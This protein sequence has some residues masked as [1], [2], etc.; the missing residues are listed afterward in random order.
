MI[1]A[2]VNMTVGDYS[3]K[4]DTN[5]VLYRGDR[6]VEIRF[7]IKGNRFTV[8]DSTYAQM[9]IRRPSATSV[10]SDPAP[11]QNDTVVFTISEDMIDELK[12]IG[13]YTFQ[14][15]LYD[16]SMNARATLPPCEGCLIINQ[17]IATEGEAL[18]NA[19]MI[20]DSAVLAAAYSDVPEDEIFD[21]N[22]AYNRTVW[23]DGDIITDV[24]MNKIENAL[25]YI[26]EKGGGG[27]ATAPYI[28]TSLP[29]TVMIGSGEDF[30]LD[31]DF[32]SP[33]LGK[34]T[35]KVFINDVDSMNTK[36]DQGISITTIPGSLFTKGTN[37]VVI[38]VLD[39]VGMMSNSLTFY[40]RYGGTEVSSTFDAYVSYDYGAT[41]RY[42]FT[43]TALDTSLQLTFYMEIDGTTQAGVPCV[44]DVRSYYTFPTNLS[45][46]NHYCRAWVTDG[47]TRSN[48]LAF[49]LIILDATSLVVATDTLNPTVEEGTQLV[50]DYKVYMK[51]NTSF[52]TKTYVDNNLIN[53][54]TCTLE[55]AYYRTT[56]LTAGTHTIKV[57][58]FDVTE[59][60]SDFVTW[61]VTVTESTYTMLE[62]AKAGSIFMAT[63]YNK[64]NVDENR[65]VWIGSS[66]DDDDITANLSNFSFNS[67]NGWIDDALVISGNSWVEIPIQPLANNAQYGFTL[68]IEF[69]TKA[70]GVE[71][72]EVLTLWNE[73]D[74]CG[75]KITTEQLIMRSKS[76]SQCDLYFAEDE[77][78]S[79]IFVIDRDEKTAK[80]YLNGVMCE[81]F[82]LS[83]YEAAGQKYLEDFTVNSNVYLGGY[84]KNGYCAI[85][86]IR[87]YEVAL[88]TNEILNNF[89][90]N[91]KDKAAQR[92]LVEFQKGNTLPT[93]TIYCDFAGLGKDDKKPCNIVYNSPDVNLYGESFTLDGKHSMLQYQGTSSMQYPIKNYRINPRNADGKVKLDPFNN[94]VGESRFTLKADFMSSGHWQNTG[95]AKWVNDKLYNYNVNDES[96]MNAR[97]WYDL[98]NGGSLKG[99]REAINGFPCRLILVNDGETAL[100]EGQ[101]EPTPGNT[102]DMGIFNFNNDKDNVETLGFDTDIFPNCMSFEVTANSDTSAGAFVPYNEERV[103]NGYMDKT[104]LYI[105]YMYQSEWTKLSVNFDGQIHINARIYWYDE[106]N[107][108]PWDLASAGSDGSFDPTYRSNPYFQL[109]F[110]GL[111]QTNDITINDITYKIN[112]VSSRA[113]LYSEVMSTVVDE[114]SELKYLQNSF[115]LRYPDADDVGKDYGY[116]GMPVDTKVVDIIQNSGG[117]YSSSLMETAQ[118]GGE[119]NISNVKGSKYTIYIYF[120]GADGY[121]TILSSWYDWVQTTGATIP[122][123]SEAVYV[124]IQFTDGAD[125]IIV[126]GETYY[127]GNL[128]TGSVIK[129]PYI[130]STISSDYGL[131]RVIDW[132]GNCTDEQFVAEFDQYFHRDYTLRY[133]LLVITLG[134]VDNLGKNM[135][136]DTFD[137]KIWLPRFYDMD[138]ICSYDNSGEIKFDVDI[139]MEQGYWNTSSSRLWTKIRDLMHDEL[140]EKYN[141]MRQ[142][143]M[144][145][146]SFMSYFYDK[147]IA[148]IPQTYYNKDY[149]VKYAPYAD[150]Y[151]GKAHGDGYEHL[152]RWLKRRL[153]FT[154]TLFDY[155]PSYTND[156]LTIRA[157]TLDLM[158]LEIE[159]YTPVYQHVSF[160]NGNMEKIK[161]DGKTSTVFNGTAQTA[162]D[163]EV[164][165]YGGSNIKSIKGIQSMNPD[166]M[167]IGNATRL[168]EL[169]I[170]DCPILT[171]VN[172]NKAN[173]SPHTYLNKLDISNCPQLGGTLN[174]S[175]SPLLQE[176]NALGSVV[177]NVLFSTSV[178]NLET[179]RVPK[180]VTSLALNDAGLL[181]T[182]E[183]EEGNNL[184]SISLTNCNN[185][186][187]TINFDLTQV[188][189]VLLDNSYNGEE[190][191]MSETTNLTLKNMPSL[192]RVIFTP[193]SEYSAFDINN[194]LNSANYKITTFNNPMMTDFITTAPHRL[195]YN[196]VE[197]K[198]VNVTPN[199]LDGHSLTTG[200]W[201]RPTTGLDDSSGTINSMLEYI[202]V[203]ENTEYT[204]ESSKE[205]ASTICFYNSSQTFISA[206]DKASNTIPKTFTTPTGTSYIRFDV[207]N[208]ITS[209][210]QLYLY[211]TSDLEYIQVKDYGDIT[212]NTAFTANTLDLADTQFQNVKFL[213]T[214]DV[215]NLKV[216]TTM[217]NFYCDSAM[218]I[219]T[220]VIED[221]S[222]E[223]IHEE[224]IEP[225]TTNYDGEVLKYTDVVYDMLANWDTLPNGQSP[226]PS[227]GSTAN[228]LIDTTV[229]NL[230]TTDYISVVPGTVVTW[231]IEGDLSDEKFAEYDKDKKFI[232]SVGNANSSVNGNPAGASVTLSEETHYIRL[233]VKRCGTYINKIELS[234]KEVKVPNII[235]SSA[236]GS[237]IFN[238]YSNNTTQPTST[239]PYMWDLTGLKLEDFYTYGMNNWVKPSDDSYEKRV[240]TDIKSITMPQRMPGYSV[241]LVN[242][243][244]TPDEYPT[245]LYPKLIDTGLPITGKLDYTSYKGTSLAWAYAYTTGDVSINPLDSRSQGNI[246]QDYNKL[247]GTD[248]VDIV[249]VWIYKDTDLSKFSV[250]STIKKMY[251]ELTSSN[252]GSRTQEAY[253]YFP[254][255]TEIYYFDDGS[256][257]TLSST[258]SGTNNPGQNTMEKIVFMEGYFKNVTVLNRLTWYQKK[259]KSVDIKGLNSGKVTR[260]E[261]MFMGLDN[262]EEVIGLDDFNASNV[263][264]AS[265]LFYNCPKFNKLIDL[266][267]FTQLQNLSNAFFGCKALTQAPTIP[268]SV[269][270]MQ[271]TFQGCSSLTTAPV[272][273]QGVTNMAS[274]FQNCTSLTQAPVIPSGVTNMHS[275]FKDCK[276]LTQAPAI[277]SSVTNMEHTFNGCTSLTTAPT[278]PNSVTNASFCFQSCTSLT[279]GA[280]FESTACK[281]GQ[282]YRGCTNLISCSLPL[283]GKDYLNSYSECV[284]KCE[285][286]TSITWLGE[287]NVGFNAVYL[288][289][290]SVPIETVKQAISDLIPEHLADLTELGTTATLTLGEYASYLS[291][292]EILSAQNKG[293]TLEGNFSGGDYAIIN[294]STDLSSVEVNSDITMVIV[295]LTND[296]YKTRL[297]EVYAKYPS[298]TDVLFTEDGTVTTLA[299]MFNN[300]NN[301]KC[302]SKIKKI[303]F[304]EG[305]FQN[306]TNLTYS[307]YQCSSLTDIVNIPSG[308]TNMYRTFYYCSD[309]ENVPD[310]P[311]GVT[312][313]NYTFYQC[314]SLVT[315]P[316]LGKSTTVLDY[317]FYGCDCLETVP[318]FPPNITKLT[319][320]FS[321]CSKLTSVPDIPNS[322]GD[323]SNA[324]YDCSRLVVAPKLPTSVHT[325][326]STFYG[327]SSLTTPPSII[328]KSVT[329][330]SSCFNGCSSLVTPPEFEHIDGSD[331][332]TGRMYQNCS[333][334]TTA[335]KI[336]NGVDNILGMFVGC[337]ALTIPPTIPDSVTNMQEVFNN[338]TGLTQNPNVPTGV[339]NLKWAFSNSSITA[340][341]IPLTNLTTYD[342]AISSCPN[343][344]DVTWVGEITNTFN[345]KN[346]YYKSSTD[347]T[348]PTATDIQEL[349]P[350]HLGTVTGKTLT[351]GD[352]ISHLS[353]EEIAAAVA[354]GWTIE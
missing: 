263:T 319:G 47:T 310:L 92:A 181:Y 206:L 83:D 120:Y 239:S 256:I 215:Y 4:C 79:A 253:G 54:G 132:V 338:C 196:N 260:M 346:L 2:T 61:T 201:L 293:W 329:N 267:N 75:I 283:G 307:F 250:N 160:Y 29:E 68:D 166:S 297:N 288:V 127:K 349:V 287:I 219:D 221:A 128:I 211:K 106:L 334:M 71:D 18:V 1:Y 220:D 51:N 304:L 40:I 74:N 340:I 205:V 165:I 264:I 292:G 197:Y 167:L 76:G 24:R 199:L 185:L 302:R 352:Y 121:S 316:K 261:S 229:E 114:N 290:D 200:R 19:A 214:T 204:L 95:L 73:T 247:Y 226:T 192:K 306:L 183:M 13:A 72:A 265:Q 135:M 11:I 273:P 131:K 55:T 158:S 347:N 100:N 81:A 333:K 209:V 125:H 25:Y 342:Y 150:E 27:T 303:E 175:N 46:G 115:E 44:S 168:T 137:G 85:K 189:T 7:V 164:L 162:T 23:V 186:T 231:K 134:M 246:T 328:P 30:E 174:I 148:Q 178:R 208:T 330:T 86:N 225:Y 82:A 146:E 298:M 145:Y 87:I 176:V 161:I 323:M 259:L 294:A 124:A 172:S 228:D 91:E 245:M 238:M 193:N 313:V 171:V 163:Q 322:V 272:I 212:P 309:L 266:S 113:D 41:V 65:E 237:L 89:M 326:S 118:F 341:T 285:S 129:E 32:S 311:D 354:K 102:K 218:D 339:T 58:V 331:L 141:N 335:P 270:T 305:Y 77:I 348:T 248:F 117:L 35:L 122:I 60:Y 143:G 289:H 203:E 149:D 327:C 16:N 28:S 210:E 332:Y 187:E 251:I 139:E 276:A 31:L 232:K 202:E 235:P 295:E 62:P 180:T 15:R 296:N 277:P 179:L 50:L 90:S 123:P 144:S 271:G 314:D 69:K 269:T 320:T 243:D 274:T 216:P 308:V 38:Y 130:K 257:S 188:P 254:N 66:Q 107:D 249:D 198:N 233:S 152:K 111:G 279:T 350:E 317:T 93:L 5:I 53:T 223:V 88:A 119:L 21:N 36:I 101:Q 321:G 227:V 284:W 282:L 234:Y 108:T 230:K 217:K 169:D 255:A 151:M 17:P 351:L 116:L 336:P 33:N 184:Q 80:I 103:I 190:L 142:N 26:N 194:V 242:A 315:A 126:N 105:N 337:K 275:T 42:Y 343:L 241:R 56:N 109:V 3:S 191:Y 280:T 236:N 155:A 104:N 67:E 34:G 57:E 318:E 14:V 78:V 98:Q 345:V 10:F 278:I 258:Y 84:N 240:L 48:V 170:S 156:A 37:M 12:E 252:Y 312:N 268:N 291:I 281:I 52:I 157:N 213:C 262:L 207:T 9:I 154:D 138:T 301:N 325:L 136:F 112:Y 94:G 195:S 99:T 299:D 300:N 224:L 286:L 43:P 22:N 59:T 244:I 133:Y 324:F 8:L 159:T 6:N 49:N 353:E 153:I 177:D 110:F 140:V 147:Q 96:T 63:A 45:V 64:S 344:T 97:K 39:R 222:Y 70:I 182:L 20:N 173:F